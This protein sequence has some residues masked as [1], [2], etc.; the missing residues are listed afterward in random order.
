MN[1]MLS[2]LVVL[3]ALGLFANACG[4]SQA[5]P[6]EPAA[7]G[8]G[9][10]EPLAAGT[11]TPAVPPP[12]GTPPN[13]PPAALGDDPDADGVVGAQDRCPNEPEDRDGFQDEDGCPDPDNDGDGISDVNDLCPVEAEDADGVQDEDGCPDA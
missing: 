8:Q 13:P 1:R 9:A 12:E 2:M 6:Q 7:T 3:A 10:T 4:P 11:E 5:S